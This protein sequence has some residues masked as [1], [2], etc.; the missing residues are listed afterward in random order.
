[1]P[2]SYGTVLLDFSDN[3][4]K[5]FASSVARYTSRRYHFQFQ[6]G[7]DLSGRTSYFEILYEICYCENV[8]SDYLY[9]RHNASVNSKHQ[10]PPG[11]TLGVLHSPAAPGAG[12]Y[13]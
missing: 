6:R 5:S 13:T 10:H 4:R 8:S 3:L 12:I 9:S 1:M 11:A 7:S 2:D